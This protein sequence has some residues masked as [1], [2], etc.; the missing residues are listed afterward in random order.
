MN[1]LKRNSG[2]AEIY[3]LLAKHQT[4]CLIPALN[5]IWNSRFSTFG[6]HCNLTKAVKQSIQDNMQM[7]QYVHVT[8]D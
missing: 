8:T 7:I 5:F 6:P 3:K 4:F 2:I 1:I